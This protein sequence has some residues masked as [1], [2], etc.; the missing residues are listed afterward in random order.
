MGE[1]FFVSIDFSCPISGNKRDNTTVRVVAGFVFVIAVVALMAALR[2]SV[3]TAAILTGVL[4]IDFVIRAFIK[5]KYSPLATLARGTVSG[6]KLTKKLVDNA[7]KIFAARIGVLFSVAS[8]VLFAS[9][10]RL[11]GIIV[12]SILILCAALESFFGI[13]LGCLMYSVLPKKLGNVLSRE[14]VR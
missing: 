14:Y 4:A 12:L 9:N 10:L 2:N 6:L 11:S 1:R 13:C 5:P 8:T 3:Q 7:P